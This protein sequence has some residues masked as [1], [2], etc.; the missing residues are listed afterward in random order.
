MIEG[1][2]KELLEHSFETLLLQDK[3]RNCI[4]VE[5]SKVIDHQQYK[6]TR[7]ITLEDIVSS[8][9]FD[10]RMTII[11]RSMAK[12]IENIPQKNRRRSNDQN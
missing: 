6:I 1:L 7:K 3:E 12:E 10:L 2:L 4:I 11:L 5:M 8:K 9:F